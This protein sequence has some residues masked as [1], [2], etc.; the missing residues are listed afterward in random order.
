MEY[1]KQ[2]RVMPLCLECGDKI[3]YGRADKK[4]C[5]ESCKVRYY[6][7][8]AKTGRTYRRR[9]ISC[10]TKNY[11]ILEELVK[12]GVE[13]IALVDII[14]LGF[15]PGIMTAHSRS[16]GR[17]EYSC[18][19]IKYIMTPTRLYS[20]SKIKNVSINLQPEGNIQK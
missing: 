6:N 3:S 5:C 9:V 19:D 18:F 2:N 1:K 16:R 11:N 4:F 10:I 13:S 7:N 15:M 17:E 8:M 20:I 14:G 12:S